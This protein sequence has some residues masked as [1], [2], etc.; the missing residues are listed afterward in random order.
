MTQPYD[1]APLKTWR[2]D[3]NTIIR[4]CGMYHVSPKRPKLQLTCRPGGWGPVLAVAF[5]GR[6]FV[7]GFHANRADRKYK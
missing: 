5:F 4:F 6:M 7:L 2:Y 3:E 1:R